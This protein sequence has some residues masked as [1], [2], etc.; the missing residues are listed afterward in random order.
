MKKT[1]LTLLFVFACS[2]M[3]AQKDK[4]LFWEISGNGLSKKSYV[5][6]T[7]H[8]NSKVSY[9][10]SDAFFKHLLNADIVSNESD[11]ETWDKVE[12]LLK[13]PDIANQSKFYSAFYLKQIQKNDLL[14]L[15]KNNDFFK[16]LLSGVESPQSDY[17]EDTVLDS[18]IYQTGKKYKKKIVGLE[19]AVESTLSIL[20]ISETD[21]TPDE[22]NK[23]LLMK[24]IKNGNFP[25]TLKDYYR[26]KDIVMLDSIY[27]LMFSKKAHDALIV[28]RNKDMANSIDSLSKTGSLFAAVGAAH[29][30]G[31]LGIIQLLIDKGYTL[32]PIF[33]EMSTVG[34]NKKNEIESFFP[35]PGFKSFTSNDLMFTVPLNK[36]VIVDNEN[37]GSPDFTNGGA[38]NIKRLLLNNFLDK[39]NQV[40]N[41][42]SLDSLFFEN[43]PG[44]IESKNYFK[45]NLVEVYDIKN[46]TKNGNF[47][48]WKFYITPLEIISFSM[49]GNSTYTS[50]FENEIFNNIKL[51]TSQPEWQTISIDKLNFNLTLPSYN[52]VYGNKN[53]ELENIEIQA[54]EPSNNSYYFLTEHCLNDVD[55]LESTAFENHQLHYEFY[56][57]HDLKIQSEVLDETTN[58]MISETTLGNQKFSLKS[59]INGDKYFLLGTVN[60]T[61]DQTA[62]YF[63]SFQATSKNIPDEVFAD[64]TN[65]DL[66]FKVAVP[67]KTNEKLFLNLPDNSYEDKNIFEAKNKSYSFYSASGTALKFRTNRYQKYYS[68]A[69]IDSLKVELRKQFLNEPYISSDVIDSSYVDYDDDY[70]D[71]N[72]VSLLD[73]NVYTRKGFQYSTWYKKIE[74]IDPYQILSESYSFDT[75]KKCHVFDALVGK[76]NSAQAIKHKV[77]FDEE[78]IAGFSVLVDKNYKNDNQFIEKT[79]NSFSFLAPKTTSVFTDKWNQFVEDAHSEKDTLRFSALNSVYSLDLKKQNTAQIIDFM[80]N[81]DFKDSELFALE[82]LLEHSGSLNDSK[83]IPYLEQKYKSENVKTAI[84][85][86]ILKA[87]VNQH[88]KTGYQKIME[89]LEYDLPISDDQYEIAN[90]FRLFENDIENSKILYPKIVEFHSI[91]E[92]TLP[93]LS[94]CNKLLDNRKVAVNKLKGYKKIIQ[95][96]AKLEY[97]RVLSWKEKNPDSNDSSDFSSLISQSLDAAVGSKEDVTDESTEEDDD[98]YSDQSYMSFTDLITYINLLSH[99]PN[100]ESNTLLFG[101]IAK[102]KIPEITLELIRIGVLNNTLSEP[103]LNKYLVSNDYKF[104]T[105]QLLL[106]QN[107]FATVNRFSDE[108]IAK[109]AIYNFET[110]TKKDKITFVESQDVTYNKV[111]SKFFF[112]EILKKGENKMPNEKLLCAVAFVSDGAKIDP[113]AYRYFNTITIDETIKR[114]EEIQKIILKFENESRLRA[115]F[116]KR[117]SDLNANFY[118]TY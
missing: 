105:L 79:I 33:D 86:A 72:S 45:E 76:T 24:L 55:Y 82:T 101:K 84:Q 60:A 74:T 88:S 25:E 89:L 51:K 99:F 111:Q 103:E 4:T 6:G 77:Y 93:I 38:I 71:Y 112:F 8:V 58:S 62:S 44:T 48:H 40:F 96:N 56:L 19:D 18:F 66:N 104:I 90:L 46:K 3:N 29:L 43:I 26:E 63:K 7:M 10:L 34:T 116:E 97:K 9:H 78:T 94:F 70:S 95:T 83:I 81:F 36:K 31:K 32:T 28:N 91:K 20:R 98:D 108:E 27:K 5:Y 21:A 85:I 68:T 47:Q 73:S 117:N 15:F 87:L 41:H 106:N 49:T 1:I 75:E 64:F 65:S 59:V 23:E 107:N 22:K 30:S 54:Y 80:D 13:S 14:T 69:S 102:L 39:K 53:D 11:P 115:S 61:V 57:Q 52:L 37:I 35:N 92:Y 114:E 67:K 110:I 16:N 100:D 12:H 2:L 17:Q 50:L 118:P 42:K 113:S 109:S